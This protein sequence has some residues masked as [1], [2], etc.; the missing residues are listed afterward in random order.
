MGP[1]SKNRDDCE[2]LFYLVFNTQHI[3]STVFAS[4]IFSENIVFNNYII[5]PVWL[6]LTNTFRYLL[7]SNSLLFLIML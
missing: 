3:T 6:D 2:F 1:F 4:K 7:V 5:L